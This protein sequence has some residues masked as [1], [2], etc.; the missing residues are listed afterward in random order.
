MGIS[1]MSIQAMLTF[2]SEI[3]SC[4]TLKSVARKTYCQYI[5]HPPPPHLQ[6]KHRSAFFKKKLVLERPSFL[7]PVSCHLHHVLSWKSGDQ[8][9]MAEVHGSRVWTATAKASSIFAY[10]TWYPLIVWILSP[11]TILYTKMS[12][13]ARFKDITHPFDEENH[14][15]IEQLFTFFCNCLTLGQWELA[16]VCLR[17]L[18]QK[19]KKL[20]KPFKDVVRAVIDQPHVCRY[21]RLSEFCCVGF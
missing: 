15:E 5:V 6:K 7:S 4:S 18:F 20:G 9:K 2:V 8:N 3:I 13:L 21:Y 16:R 11:L 19:Q 12:D 10:S 17:D 1:V 14:V